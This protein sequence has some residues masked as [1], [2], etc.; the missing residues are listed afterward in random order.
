MTTWIASPTGTP[1]GDG[2]L[3]SPWDLQTA[4][5]KTDTVNHGDTLYLRGGTYTGA[6]TA[7][8]L[9][10]AGSLITVRP[11]PGERVIFDAIQTGEPSLADAPIRQD[12]GGYVAYRGFEFTNSDTTRIL[13]AGGSNP[14]TRRAPG[15]FFTAPGC[16]LINCLIYDL[17]EG[18]SFW[19]AA[20]GTEF[21]GNVVWNNGWNSTVDGNHGHG[22]Y[23]QGGTSERTIQN[24]ILVNSFASY[25]LHAYGSGAASLANL[26][27]LENILFGQSL[28]GGDAIVST[29]SFD[30]NDVLGNITFGYA[31]LATDNSGLAVTD[32]R[33][34][35]MSNGGAYTS[36]LLVK[37]FA[38][39]QVTITG[40]AFHNSYSAANAVHLGL[41][42]P[43]GGSL[44]TYTINTNTYRRTNG[45]YLFYATPKEI[46]SPTTTIPTWAEWQTAGY[47]AD[48][49]YTGAVSAA[50]EDYTTLRVNA[51]DAT[52]AHLLV[53]NFGSADSK[54]VDLSSFATVGDYI[55]IRNV[56]D[57]FGDVR[58]LK[59]G[60]D[61][62]SIDMR[63]ASHSVAKPHGYDTALSTTSFPQYGVFVLEILPASSG[64]WRGIIRKTLGWLFGD[65]HP[66]GA[67]WYY[68]HLQG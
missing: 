42:A 24:N 39:G 29:C 7:T 40:N 26:T 22:L 20:D 9:G 38:D 57:Y 51:Y 2:S 43:T 68:R 64:G 49:T 67:E 60:G 10:E 12:E 6:F 63:A 14:E 15:P 32:N 21:Y 16:K 62:V 4:L 45:G 18:P 58:I 52:R 25:N 56:Q 28:V 35:L 55:R 66:P 59:Y 1:E 54:S 53:S 44:L 65:A 5:N 31:D 46:G 17:S 41:Y 48:G 3:G 34:S 11:Y 36:P 47:D 37:Y 27:I 33:F 23:C 19:G 13:T 61:P 30:D 50:G 8:L